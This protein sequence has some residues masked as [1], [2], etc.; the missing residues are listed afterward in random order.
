[1]SLL[2]QRFQWPLPA[3]GAASLWY[4]GPADDRHT[5]ASEVSAVRH[6]KAFQSWL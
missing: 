6:A 4:N 5:S 2:C 1:M 3:A